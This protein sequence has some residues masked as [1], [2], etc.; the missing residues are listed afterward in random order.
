MPIPCLPTETSCDVRCPVCGR[1]FLLLS[2]PTLLP[3]RGSL[4]ASARKSLAAQHDL[5]GSGRGTV[6]PDEVFDLPAWD[7]EAAG[8]ESHPWN[9]QMAAWV[10]NK[11]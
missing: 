8:E 3:Q 7:G 1:G 5:A 6:H 10:G 11:S 2:E 4:R 9:F